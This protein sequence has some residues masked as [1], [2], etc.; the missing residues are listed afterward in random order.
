MTEHPTTHAHRG[1]EHEGARVSAADLI[2]RLRDE[3][4]QRCCYGTR[5]G[6][7]RTCDCKFGAPTFG[8]RGEMT[9][10]PELRTAIRLLTS[11]STTNPR[12]R[13]GEREVG[14]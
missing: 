11:A 6:D 12:E 9:G 3:Q 14:A 1:H 10:C 7:G 4:N 2:E 13:A 5:D 8:V